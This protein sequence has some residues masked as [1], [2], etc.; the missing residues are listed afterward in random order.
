[1]L[2]IAVS[3]RPNKGGEIGGILSFHPLDIFL[4]LFSMCEAEH[5]VCPVSV[6]ISLPSAVK[7][8]K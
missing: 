8:R 4:L 5:S 6:Q 7:W 3:L 1:M 2:F